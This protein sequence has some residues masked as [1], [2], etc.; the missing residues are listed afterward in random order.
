MSKDAKP[1]TMDVDNNEKEEEEKGMNEWFSKLLTASLKK[2]QTICGMLQVGS[3]HVFGLLAV[4][5]LMD[6]SG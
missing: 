1:V 4:I 2:L 6:G 3:V 5:I